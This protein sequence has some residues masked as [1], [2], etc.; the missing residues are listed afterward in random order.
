MKTTLTLQTGE[1]SVGPLASL[2][3]DWNHFWFQPASPV[4]LGL[5]RIFAG[6]CIFYIHLAYSVDLQE[7]FGANAW[8]DK[9]MI[10]DFRH[11]FPW[12]ASPL[13]WGESEQTARLPQTPEE[14]EYTRKW[15]VLPGQ[16]LNRGFPCWSIWY[17]V[18]DPQAMR[19]VHLGILLIILLFTMGF[20]SRVTSVLTWIGVISYIQ[21][22]PTTLFGM[23]TMMNLVLL[24][25]IVGQ[26]GSAL[27]VDRLISRYWATRRALR[28]KRPAPVDLEPAPSV[29]ANLGLRLMQ[30]NVCIIYI[31]AGLSK[32][33]GATWWSFNAIWFTMANPEF[34]PMHL[35]IYDW[36]LRFLC[37]HR[38]LWELFMS[39]GVVFTLFMEIGFPFLVWNRRL[40]WTMVASAAMLHTGIALFMGLNTFGLMM[41]LLVSSFIPLE[42]VERFLAFLGQGAPRLRLGC[43][44]R[45]PRQLRA[46]SLVR[47]FDVWGQVEMVDQGAGRSSSPTART[48]AMAADDR[49]LHLLEPATGATRSGYP[50]FERVVRGLRLLWPVA[51]VTW[52]PGVAALGRTLYPP[53]GTSAAA[54]LLSNNGHTKPHGEAVSR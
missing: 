13:D 41:M 10:D 24:Y 27:S 48:V 49:H 32:L 39:G 28:E 18:T 33:Q 21:R 34:S 38:L 52:I 51:W 12:P 1:A 22:S 4:P 15:G 30:V 36:S 45:D 40:R 50:L 17:H 25:L 7:F 2:W 14:V 42:A 44:S 3:R 35:E 46:A 6:L 20:C 31:A 19:W 11:D 53:S 43:N 5:I 54:A 8:V 29:A 26:S 9:Q 23:D 37:R 47:A 16:V